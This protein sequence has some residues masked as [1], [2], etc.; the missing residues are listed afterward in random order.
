MLD[1]MPGKPRANTKSRVLSFLADD[2]PFSIQLLMQMEKIK[3]IRLL[4]T[5]RKSR[6]KVEALK[7]ANSLR[8]G[9]SWAKQ[10]NAL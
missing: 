3:S 4:L 9:S 10:L 8:Q 1:F 7:S 5:V 6:P 2:V